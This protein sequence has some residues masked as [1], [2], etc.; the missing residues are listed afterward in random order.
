MIR[1]V[2]VF[3]TP[4]EHGVVLFK[5]ASEPKGF[6]QITGGHN[7][8]FLTSGKIYTDGLNRFISRYL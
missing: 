8:G 3:A 1:T 6:L 4:Y 5:N 7:E 2:Y